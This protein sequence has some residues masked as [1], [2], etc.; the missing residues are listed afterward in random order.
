MRERDARTGLAA[1]AAAGS[2]M[3]A[4]SAA[5]CICRELRRQ[6]AIESHLYGGMSPRDYRPIYP[7]VLAREAKSVLN[8]LKISRFR[9]PQAAFRPIFRDGMPIIH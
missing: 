6:Y 9:V 7:R 8:L 5:A 4:E 1:G 3:A 2:A